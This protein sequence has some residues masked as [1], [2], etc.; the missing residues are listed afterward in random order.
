MK[1]YLISIL[2]ISAQ[3]TSPASA[4]IVSGAVTGGTSLNQGG[5][6]VKLTVP[7]S[8]STP[9]NTVGNDTFQTPNLY[10]FDEGQN[11]LIT[12][13]LTVNDLADGLGGGSGPGIIPIGSTV[14]SH[15]I[16]FDPLNSTNVVGSIYFNSDILGIIT[17]TPNLVASDF[18]IDTGVNYLKPA[19]RGLEPNDNVAITGLQTITGNLSAN[20]PGD[21][22]RVLTAFS[23]VTAVPTPAAI[24]LFGFSL[25][26]LIGISRRKIAD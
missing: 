21:Y 10:G 22:I 20:S 23:P 12:N 1:A 25:I 7:F 3:F 15:Y 14:A 5:H 17:N 9:A 4:T 24:W 19:A 18:L 16:S 2:I 13:N 8:A 26:A 6:F 11:I